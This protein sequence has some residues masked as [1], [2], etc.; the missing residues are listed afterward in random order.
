MDNF[1]FLQFLKFKE[2]TT[3]SKINGEWVSKKS[4]E[5]VRAFSIC[6]SDSADFALFVNIH[7]YETLYF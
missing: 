1:D 2:V 4:E 5:I 7:Q 6:P 3:S